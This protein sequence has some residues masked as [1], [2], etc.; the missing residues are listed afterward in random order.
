MAGLTIDFNDKAFEALLKELK[1]LFPEIRAQA[2]GYVGNEG[3]KTLK[4]KFLS[5]QEIDLR[6]Y[7]VDKAGRRTITYSVGKDA[8]YVKISSYPVNLFERGRRLKS[9]SKE[10]GKR[11]ITKKLKQVMMSDMARLTTEFDN[12]YLKKKVSKL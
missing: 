9:G 11:I 7:P 3:R 8:R 1:I 6:A 12:K 5:G 10:S 4:M 2:L